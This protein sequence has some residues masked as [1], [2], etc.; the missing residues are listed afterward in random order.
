MG[1]YRSFF[2]YKKADDESIDTV[3][4][5]LARIQTEIGNAS[6][7]NKPTVF[8]KTYR[9]LE[10]FMN[11]EDLST[12]IEVI[13]QGGDRPDF[14]SIAMRLKEAQVFH[15]SKSETAKA[16]NSGGK[17]DGSA[18]KVRDQNRWKGDNQI[19]KCKHCGKPHRGFCIIFGA[20]P[21]GQAELKRRAK[22]LEERNRN[23]DGREKNKA[24]STREIERG[25]LVNHKKES[26]WVTRTSKSTPRQWYF[27]SGCTRHMTPNRSIF[28]TFDPTAW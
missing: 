11:D 5:S 20:T 15:K 28:K 19:P 4:S 13:M 8:M 21:E 2:S 3:A 9:L 6:K 18:L 27:D 22:E 16:A 12:T 25:P 23:S 1:L 14:T 7:E 10:I 26:A 17:Y 24:Q